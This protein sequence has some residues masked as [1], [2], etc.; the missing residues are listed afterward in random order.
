[1]WH[2]YE[3][4]EISAVFWS[5]NLKERKKL[6][7]SPRLKGKGCIKMYCKGIRQESVDSIKLAENRD[8]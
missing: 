6:R 1:M 2:V 4:R 7:A 3:R 5:G 8:K